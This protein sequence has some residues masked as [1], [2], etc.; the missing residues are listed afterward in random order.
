M[1]LVLTGCGEAWSSR[2]PRTQE[3]A[4]STPAI[5]TEMCPFWHTAMTILHGPL[6][7]FGRPRHPVTVE[8]AGFKSRMAR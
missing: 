5:L 1:T 2:L 6:G 7:E 8:I 4:G 3:I